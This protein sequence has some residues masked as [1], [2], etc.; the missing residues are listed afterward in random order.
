MRK[1]GDKLVPATIFI[2]GSDPARC[3]AKVSPYTLQPKK[4]EYA[5]WTIIDT[6]GVTG[7]YA[8]DVEVAF[9]AG[10]KKCGGKE[11]PIA[12]GS[13]KGTRFIEAQIDPNCVSGDVFKYDVKVD[14]TTLTDP[15][16]EIGQ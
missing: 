13:A 9:L 5:Y 15:E 12:G 1:P 14:G 4:N 8:K 11:S 7:S 2:Y 10:G 3:T 16:L 6:C